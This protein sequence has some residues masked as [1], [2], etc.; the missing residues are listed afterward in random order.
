GPE[1]L[2]GGRMLATSP[3]VSTLVNALYYTFVAPW[4]TWPIATTVL[5]LAAV[6]AVVLSRT[7]A[8]AAALLAAGFGPYLIFH[9]LFQ[10]TFTGRYALPLV[11]PI[12]YC[13]AAGARVL[14]RSSGLIVIALAA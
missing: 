13:A 6:G 4:A 7:N 1:D 3:T 11:I 12:A 5:L 9:L 2:T 14:P 10:E 8:R